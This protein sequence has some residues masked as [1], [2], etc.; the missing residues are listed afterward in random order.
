MIFKKSSDLSEY[1]FSVLGLGYESRSINSFDKVRDLGE[2][3]VVG[4]TTN[5]EACFYQDNK[6][7][8]NQKGCSVIEL[9]DE[10]FQ[11]GFSESVV[12]VLKDKVG[13]DVFFDMT[14]F[15]RRR[16]ASVLKV[17]LDSSLPISSITLGYSPSVYVPPPSG[18]S[19]V[20]VVS[21]IDEKY[22]GC[23]G[24]LSK[25]V[26]LILPLGYERNKALGLISY[27]D[28]SRSFIF[29]PKSFEGSF[30]RDVIENND[31]ILMDVPGS[32]CFIYNVEDPY[33][34]YVDL[35][36]LVI[37]SLQLYRPLIAPLGPKIACA[38]S[39]LV[40]HELFPD[41]PVWR[42]SSNHS[43]YPVERQATGSIVNFKVEL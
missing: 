8:Y 26:A 38:I 14:V 39:V 17:L 6:S 40:A 11:D 25:P 22:S 37:N 12:K 19:P 41:V 1:D 23:F 21:A 13:V 34:F 43:E 31:D 28:P 15:T 30:Y 27:L 7:F 16:I 4:Y 2:C 20:R 18:V 10:C 32:D 29:L 9:S 5:T 3:L 42:I 35:K 33:S 36:T 24:D